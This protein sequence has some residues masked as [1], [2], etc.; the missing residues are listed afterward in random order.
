[1][2]AVA[3]AAA[4]GE[5]TA[6]A[7][8]KEP[9]GAALVVAKPWP[10]WPS[11]YGSTTGDGEADNGCCQARCMLLSG[12]YACSLLCRMWMGAVLHVGAYVKGVVET[13]PM[14]DLQ[15]EHVEEGS[16]ACRHG[17]VGGGE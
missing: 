9:V 12:G 4:A 13:K 16:V 1:M 15:A 10:G 6:C 7:Q 2:A 3:A 8:C 5:V 11:Q 14:A 17:R